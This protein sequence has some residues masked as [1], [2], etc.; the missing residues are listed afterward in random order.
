MSRSG[1]VLTV[2]GYKGM[3]DGI[4]TG[5]GLRALG[6]ILTGHGQESCIGMTWAGEVGFSLVLGRKD[7]VLTG[8]GQDGVLTVYRHGK[9]CSGCI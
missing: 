4:L 5:H 6:G 7:G 2:H 9:W 3:T 8:H 1:G